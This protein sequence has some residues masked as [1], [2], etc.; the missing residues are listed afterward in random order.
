[1][2]TLTLMERVPSMS[3][4]VGVAVDGWG[5]AVIVGGRVIVRVG[6]VVGDGVGVGIEV[7]QAA[8]N[9]TSRKANFFIKYILAQMAGGYSRGY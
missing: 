8:A 2:R 1:L 9:R 7:V 3:S 5:E 6:A 4:C